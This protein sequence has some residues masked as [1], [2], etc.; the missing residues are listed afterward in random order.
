MLV[1]RK[2]WRALFSCNTR[3][4]ILP[5]AWLRTNWPHVYWKF[6]GSRFTRFLFYVRSFF[7]IIYK[8]VTGLT[9]T[10]RV[11]ASAFWRLSNMRLNISHKVVSTISFIVVQVYLL[12]SLNK[13]RDGCQIWLLIVSKFT[14]L[15]NF[16]FPWN[17]QKNIDFLMVSGGMEVNLF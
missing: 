7:N 6:C 15:I 5:F 3:F 16:Y 14:R 4:K 13:F 11:L 1:F 9:K 2:I 8:T 10:E 17:H 12:S